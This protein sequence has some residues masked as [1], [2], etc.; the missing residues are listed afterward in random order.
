MSRIETCPE[1]LHAWLT[2]AIAAG[3]SDLHLAVD[4]PPML[5]CYGRLSALETARLTQ[6]DLDRLLPQL[7]GP[8]GFARFVRERNLD[9]AL[10]TRIQEQPRRFRVNFYFGGRA[11][12]A[13]LRIIPER[14]PTLEWAGFPQTVARKIAH[15]RNGL[16]LISGVTGSGK[17][18]TLAMVIQMLNAE[19]GRR[20]LTI[21]EP[22]EYV[23]PAC[24]DT[25][26]TQREVGSD[27]QSFADGLKYGLR[28]DPD[29][30]LVGEVRDQDTAQMALSAA[31]TGHLVFS[32]LHTR[33]AKGAISRFIDLFPRGT[34][35]PVRSQLAYGLR[36][37]ISQHLLPSLQ[38]AHKP[39]LALEILFNT[40]RVRS[41]I[42]QDKMHS[43]DNTIQTSRAEGM[44]TLADSVRQLLQAQRIDAQVAERYLAET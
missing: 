15:F 44:V 14:I 9:F 16:V 11:S 32:T 8:E 21:E 7:S 41:A 10:Q 34:Q 29:V 20:I 38:P 22:I 36:A 4:H 42:A 3:A 28:Q 26:V 33:D 39:E 40:P 12:G 18:T 6:P 37:V 13:C 27:V 24:P 35:D 1:P 17:T 30:I 2:E 43:I 5:R 19:G 25:I 23:F 31:E